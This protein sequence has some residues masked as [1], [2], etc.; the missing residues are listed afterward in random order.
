MQYS[1]IDAACRLRKVVDL[2]VDGPV[3]IHDLSLTERFAVIFDLPVVF[4]LEVAMSGAGFPYR[5]D[6]TYRARVGLLEREGGA[7]DV[8]WFDV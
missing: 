7:E 1:V 5:W 2:E 4:D 6:P 8:R 3:S